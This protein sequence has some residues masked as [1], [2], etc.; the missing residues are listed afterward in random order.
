MT[1]YR[2]LRSVRQLAAECPAITEGQLR[3]WIFNAESNGIDMALVRIGGRIYID[4]DAFNRWLERNRS[5]TID[6]IRV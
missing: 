2:N 4:V 1:D 6:E 3:W 5:Q